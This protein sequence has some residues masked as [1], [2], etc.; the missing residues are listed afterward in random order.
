M[1]LQFGQGTI[2]NAALSQSADFISLLGTKK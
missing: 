1:N 2:E